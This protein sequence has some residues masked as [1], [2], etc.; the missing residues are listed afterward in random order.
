M[1]WE[2]NVLRVDHASWSGHQANLAPGQGRCYNGALEGASQLE[3]VR[4]AS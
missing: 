4:P 3:Y 2:T 1:S